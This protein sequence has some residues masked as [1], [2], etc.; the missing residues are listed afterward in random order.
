MNMLSQVAPW[1]LVAE[2]YAE[3]TMRFFR[4][5]I[6]AALALTGVQPDDEILDVACGP[7]TLALSAA[8]MAASVKAIDFSEN[9]IAQLRQGMA[10]RGIENIEPRQGDGQS[11]PYPD[12]AFN[13]AF[14]MFGL[15]FFPERP[16]G[17]AE[18]FRTL[19][20]GGRICITSWAPV[21]RS[22]IMQVMFGALRAIKPDMRAEKTDL[23]SLEDPDL[24]SSEIVA[25][26][27]GDV[28][29]HGV[30]QSLSI[31]SAEAFWENTVRGSAPVRM[32]QHSMPEEAWRE[33]STIA[34]DH[35]EQVIGT[36]PVT[37]SADAWLG[38]GIK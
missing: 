22:P 1:D 27:F 33:K 2:G 11:L 29:V 25:A 20:P 9:M 19:K 18:I 21:E 15:M 14:S 3:T 35:L 32:L 34:I 5:C 8:G 26:G 31:E 16:R 10:A 37:L 17:Y 36:F 23:D 30:T 12:A 24:L 4:G 7:G 28:A 6:E 38:I 13:A